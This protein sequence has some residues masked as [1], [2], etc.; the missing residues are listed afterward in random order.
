MIISKNSLLK[1]W[2]TISMDEK[3]ALKKLNKLKA[4]SDK[5]KVEVAMKKKGIELRTQIKC[6]KRNRRYLRGYSIRKGLRDLKDGV[7]N[8]VQIPQA[9]LGAQFFESERGSTIMEKQNNNGAEGLVEACDGLGGLE[10]M[11][12]TQADFVG[13]QKPQKNQAFDSGLLEL[14]LS[15]FDLNLPF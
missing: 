11:E 12:D 8:F 6:L 7:S 3:K 9:S 14:P 2:R 10:P 5:L 1:S 15:D 4:K 13:V